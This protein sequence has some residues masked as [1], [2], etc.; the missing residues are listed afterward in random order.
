MGTNMAESPPRILIIEHERRLSELIEAHLQP[1]GWI[2]KRAVNASEAIDALNGGAIDLAVVDVDLPSEPFDELLARMAVIAPGLPV[3]LISP[4]NPGVPEGFDFDQLRELGVKA[5]LPT[6][7]ETGDLVNYV[8]RLLK[9]PDEIVREETKR[10]SRFAGLPG[11]LGDMKKLLEKAQKMQDD[12]AK[13]QEDLAAMRIV[14]SAGGGMVTATVNG[15]GHLVDLVINP[16]VVDPDDIEM[17]QDLIITAVKDATV[18]A[19]AD[20]E[21]RMG[22]ITSALEG[23]NL[24][25]GLLGG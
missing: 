7:F 10:M 9:L 8:R 11:G 23:L 19:Q 12:A 2:T 18:K 22:E 17:L 5:F 1:I 6:P 21:A 13:L 15:H 4:R 3:T 25:P 24:P 20:Q 16:T 14:S